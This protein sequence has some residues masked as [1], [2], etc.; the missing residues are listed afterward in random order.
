[1]KNSAPQHTILKYRATNLGKY[2]S[3]T[4]YELFSVIKG[5][6]EATDLTEKI[7]L[8]E[9]RECAKSSPSYWLQVRQENKWKKPRLT[10]LFKTELS[11]IFRG[12]T[13][14]NKNKVLFKFSADRK[15]LTI[16]YFPN[17][18]Y[19]RFYLND[20]KYFKEFLNTRS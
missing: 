5:S 17:L 19:P 8:S 18:H 7:N 15:E 3:T 11:H 6:I 10:G 9:D 13:Q 16:Y 20:L 1:M 12:D 2:K 14:R 4:H